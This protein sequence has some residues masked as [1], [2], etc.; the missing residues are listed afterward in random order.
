MITKQEKESA[1]KYQI[2]KTSVGPRR[3]KPEK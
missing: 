2:I 1:P 3:E